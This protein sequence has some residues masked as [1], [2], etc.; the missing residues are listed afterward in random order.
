MF[1]K[2]KNITCRMSSD[3]A[4]GSITVQYSSIKSTSL[5]LILTIL[6]SSHMALNLV[7]LDFRCL[8]RNFIAS[9]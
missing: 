2:H 9:K 4:S 8:S 6:S 7:G 1:K 5:L 3:I